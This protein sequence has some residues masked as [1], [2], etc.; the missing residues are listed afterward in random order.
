MFKK[1]L[2]RCKETSYFEVKVDAVSKIHAKEMVR[3]AELEGPMTIIAEDTLF[4]IIE[5]IQDN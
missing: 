2:V 1:Y 3:A 4:D 5:V